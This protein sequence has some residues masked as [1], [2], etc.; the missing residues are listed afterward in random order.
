[1]P[2]ALSFL[3]FSLSA[4]GCPKGRA[5][6]PAGQT[7]TMPCRDRCHFGGAS[8]VFG[9]PASTRDLLAPAPSELP[10]I[11]CCAE[12]LL[13]S[14]LRTGETRGKRE[15]YVW[16]QWIDQGVPVNRDSEC[17][18]L[19]CT[20]GWGGGNVTAGRGTSVLTT[21]SRDLVS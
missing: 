18:P 2:L 7:H 21:S 4:K 17:D 1:M 11:A 10:R 19:S 3:S 6:K 16:V 5:S 8:F 15:R 9:L 13:D 20:G 14:L 12:L